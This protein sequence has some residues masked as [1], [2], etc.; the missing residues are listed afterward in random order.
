MLLGPFGEV[1]VHRDGCAYYVNW[2]INLVLCSANHGQSMGLGRLD[3]KG[4]LYAYQCLLCKYFSSLH[5]LSIFFKVYTYHSWSPFDIGQSKELVM[6]I[7]FYWWARVVNLLPLKRGPMSTKMWEGI[8]VMSKI[9]LGLVVVILK[10]RESMPLSREILK[11]FTNVQNIL[12]IPLV[13]MVP[14][15]CQGPSGDSWLI[16]GSAACDVFVS[17]QKC[18]QWMYSL[19]LSSV[20]GQ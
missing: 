15:F 12:I 13:K 5:F 4:I 3:P 16:I 11:V 6:C 17:M 8:P 14:V 7:N 10:E 20:L 18:Y 2:L 1:G 19:M 9:W